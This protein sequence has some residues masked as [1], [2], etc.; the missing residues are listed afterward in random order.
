MYRFWG[1]VTG[2]LRNWYQ[3]QG[4]NQSAFCLQ[5]LSQGRSRGLS[6]CWCND[7]DRRGIEQSGE[8]AGWVQK[9]PTGL[10]YPYRFPMS[11][12]HASW[13]T[14]DFARFSLCALFFQCSRYEHS[15]QVLF[16]D[17]WLIQSV[18]GLLFLLG[19]EGKNI[20]A[21][22]PHLLRPITKLPISSYLR[23]FWQ[24]PQ[25]SAHAWLIS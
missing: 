20:L 16:A 21:I 8:G 4:S 10:Q 19:S 23:T 5:C 1:W 3:R 24:Q 17:R 25:H 7:G 22:A 14:K 11:F 12:W 9:R 13:V 18:K 2:S 15:F 6:L